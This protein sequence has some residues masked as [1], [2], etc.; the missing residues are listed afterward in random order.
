MK[1]LFVVGCFALFSTSAFADKTP[2]PPPPPPP[3]EPKPASCAIQA[4]AEG[5]AL[6]EIGLAAMLLMIN[7]KR[8]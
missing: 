8:K 1:R 4:S 6:L 2:D 5:S 3:N 7:R